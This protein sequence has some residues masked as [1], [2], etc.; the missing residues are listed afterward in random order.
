MLQKKVVLDEVALE[1]GNRERSSAKREHERMVDVLLP[2]LCDLGNGEK[3]IYKAS[4]RK[5]KRRLYMCRHS[6]NDREAESGEL[7]LITD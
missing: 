6:V 7:C 4:R 1:V 5:G 3:M 2:Y